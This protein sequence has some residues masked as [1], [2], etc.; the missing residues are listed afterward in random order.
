MG[1]HE[2]YLTRNKKCIFNL[3]KKNFGKSK[4]RN[5]ITILAIILTTMLFTSM[6]TICTG[7]YQSIQTTMQMQKGRIYDRTMWH[8][9]FF[10]ARYKKRFTLCNCSGSLK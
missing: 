5:I 7:T 6:L 9:I 3:A 2:L 1:G 8:G 10:A 4:T